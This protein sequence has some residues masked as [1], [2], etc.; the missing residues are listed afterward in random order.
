LYFKC[1]SNWE[2]QG[3]IPITAASARFFARIGTVV[4]PGETLYTGDPRFNAVIH[5]LRD[6]GDGYLR[7]VRYHSAANGSMSEQFNRDTGFM[8]SAIELTWS[9]VSLLTANWA[10]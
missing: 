9:Y 1:A 10:R 3:A 4:K 6:T 8:Q 2:A 7:R 5:S